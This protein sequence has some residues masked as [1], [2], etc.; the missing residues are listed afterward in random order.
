MECDT[1]RSKMLEYLDGD[2]AG[3]AQAE[4]EAHLSHCPG[5]R[6]ELHGLQDTVA[7]IARMPAPDPPDAFWH[8]YLREIRQK[9]AVKK[10]RSHLWNWL[11]S[12]PPRPVPA[13]AVGSALIAAVFL[14][15]TMWAERPPMPQLSS[16]AVT[17]Q[18]AISQDLDLLREMDLLEAIDLLEDWELIRFRAIEG[19]RRAT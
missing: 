10:R 15:W 16:L 3:A 9:V 7:L 2:L 17:Q 18:L 8:Q 19:P 11:A 4:L 13:L 6:E 5:C 1:Y 14:T 12:L